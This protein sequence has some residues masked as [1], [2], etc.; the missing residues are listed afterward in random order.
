M[1]LYAIIRADLEM[2]AGKMAAQAGHAFL[3]SYLEARKKTP[4]IAQQYDD[5]PPGTKITLQSP[6]LSSLLIAHQYCIEHHIPSALIVDSGHILPPH[7]DGRPIITALGIGPI[8][9]ENISELTD[10]FK[11]A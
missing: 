4:Q 7:F 1:R 2:P 8:L 5:D 3:Q 9:R 11:L 10:Q 6:D